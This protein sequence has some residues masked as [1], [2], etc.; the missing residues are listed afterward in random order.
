MSSIS[1]PRLANLGLPNWITL[2]RLV[3]ALVLFVVLSLPVDG[4][5]TAGFV[6]FLLAVGSDWIDGYVA[7]RFGLT[8]SLGRVLDPFVDKILI[9]GTLVF[10][11]AEPVFRHRAELLQPWMVVLVILRELLVTAMRGWA[12]ERGQDFSA[13]LAG[14]TK[15]VIQ[16][17]ACAAGLLFVAWHTKSGET[18]FWLGLTLA[19]SV[20][21]MVVVTVYSAWVYA[22]KAAVAETGR[23]R[24]AQN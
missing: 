17:V 11:V 2:G 3:L 10:L 12:E 19:T 8:S 23:E 22:V 18:P 9:C 5:Y 4:R 13:Q 1:L 6:I 21:L 20:W 14:K 7:R 16:S 15:M 24:A